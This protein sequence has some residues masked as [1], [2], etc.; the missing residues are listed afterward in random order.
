MKGVDLAMN[1]ANVKP[2]TKKR[3]KAVLSV[4]LV[5]AILI[6]GA[7]AFLSATDSK[8]NVFTVGNVKIELW[9]DFNG[10]TYNGQQTPDP[11][12][13]IIPGQTID[14]K[15][16]IKNT[17]KN[18]AW[19]FMAVGVPTATDENI[20]SNT[21]PNGVK[22]E[23]KAFGIQ[24][25]YNNANTAIDTWKSYFTADK[26]AGTLGTVVTNTEKELF[27]LNEPTNSGWTKLD[28]TYRVEGYVYHIFALDTIAAPATNEFDGFTTAPFESV[29]FSNDIK[30]ADKSFNNADSNILTAGTVL[31]NC[32]LTTEN[33]TYNFGD[34]VPNDYVPK[35]GDSYETED[36]YYD[37]YV[38][39][40]EGWNDEDG[41]YYKTGWVQGVKDRTKSTYEPLYSEIYGCP[42][43]S[44]NYDGC[45]NLENMPDIP[46][47]VV[48]MVNSFCNCTKITQIS[49]IPTEC[50]N[51]DSAFAGTSIISA[52]DLPNKVISARG[53]FS[54][55]PIKVAP[56]L[57]DSIKYIAGKLS[58]NNYSYNPEGIFANCEKLTVPSNIPC[59]VT[60]LTRAFANCYKLESMPTIPEGVTN[61]T[62]TFCTDTIGS[63][64]PDGPQL[65]IVTKLPQTAK[66]LDKTF[67]NCTNL[68]VAPDIPD[69]VTSMNSTFENCK[70]LKEAPV[71]P[72]SV[73][74]MN[75]TFYYC[76]SIVTAPTIPAN[77]TSLNSAFFCCTSLKGT[78]EINANPTNYLKCL[79][80]TKIS[81][82]TGSTALK[83]EIF[84]TKG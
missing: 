73:T 46:N 32:T 23:V 27:T 29:T 25:S 83:T 67:F 49:N 58:N 28:D 8:T 11:V 61:L 52:P 75:N 69:G 78:I 71:I 30:S 7:Y 34:V 84:A 15:P 12:E 17:G 21:F 48:N 76:Q 35:D 77:V 82:I 55:T 9:E 43:V 64:C 54:D 70:K 24:E 10:T 20:A 44:I 18:N 80:G 31:E 40:V 22:I 63:Q 68:V 16:Y 53:T 6:A 38:D 45:S 4:F 57:S 47:S 59:E 41:E 65:S 60:D 62:M 2:T 13:N 19:M 81:E 39:D 72:N 33:C 3:A 42:V 26:V 37:F 14:K 79:Y 5:V 56:K 51:M 36:Y 66:I 1:H 74:L 50:R